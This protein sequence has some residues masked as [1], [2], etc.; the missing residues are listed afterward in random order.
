MKIGFPVFKEDKLDSI[1]MSPSFHSC[2]HFG[3]YDT[4]SK[5]VKFFSVMQVLKESEG[6]IEFLLGEHITQVISPTCHQMAGKFFTDNGIGIY[7]AE[8]EMAKDNIDKLLNS[9]LELFDSVSA[10]QKSS[11]SSDCSSCSSDCSTEQDAGYM[12]EVVVI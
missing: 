3:V 7:R 1:I 8:S 5:G 12:Q 4:V 11:C 6:I 2:D 10:I 9:E